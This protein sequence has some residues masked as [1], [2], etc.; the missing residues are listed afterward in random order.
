MST[1]NKI[2]SKTWVPLGAAVFAVLLLFGG[3]RY[4]SGIESATVR[5]RDAVETIKE[6]LNRIEAKV[7]RILEQR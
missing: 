3:Y 2:T 5:N 7:D 1:R 6:Q 4:V